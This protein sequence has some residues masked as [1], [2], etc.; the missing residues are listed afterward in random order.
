M[1]DASTLVPIAEALLTI[2]AA[3]DPQIIGNG[4]SAVARGPGN[5]NFLLTFDTGTGV[6]DVGSGSPIVV[7]GQ[8]VPGG[9]AQRQIGPNGLDPRLARAAITVR[10][11]TTAPGSTTLASQTAEFVVGAPGA[12]ALTLQVVVRNAADAAI[13]PMGAGVPNAAGSGLEIMVWSFATPDDVTV[14]QIGP[15]FQSSMQFP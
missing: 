2:D 3:G 11:G 10:G 7:D 8:A 14:Q 12:G 1:Y 13:D 5:G 9:F 6:E 4:F 15:L